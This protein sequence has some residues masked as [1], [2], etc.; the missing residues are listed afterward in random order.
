M[1]KKL[2]DNA[3]EMASV[4]LA[5]LRRAQAEADLEDDKYYF[6]EAEHIQNYNFKKLSQYH[7]KTFDM[8]QFILTF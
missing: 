2:A 8:L 4:N 6:T 1:Y 7:R 3:E 5:K